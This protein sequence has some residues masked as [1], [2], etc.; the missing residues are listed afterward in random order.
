MTS[1][2]K[3]QRNQARISFEIALARPHNIEAVPPSATPRK[4][5]WSDEKGFGSIAV[6]PLTFRSKRRRRE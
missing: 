6:K 2:S 4:R 1:I 3:A 5:K